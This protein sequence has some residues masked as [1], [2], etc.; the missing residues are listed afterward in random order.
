MNTSVAE[1][2]TPSEND[3][4]V[5]LTK[6]LINQYRKSL[7]DRECRQQT[8]AMYSCYLNKL[9]D[10]LQGDKELSD[11]NLKHW[12]ESLRNR[13]YSDRT[14]NMYISSVNGLLRFCGHKS[15]PISVTS[16]P[17]N[18]ELPGLT[19]EEYL[20]LLSYI[21]KYGSERDY[22]LTKTLGTMDINVMD[23]SFLTVEACQKGFV[24]L[25]DH[26]QAVITD[27]LKR[28]L[29]LYIG[30]KGLSTG[31][32]FITNQGNPIDRSNLT[33]LIERYGE[34]AGLDSRK[35][36]PRALHS[37]YQRTQEEITQQLMS[38]HMQEYEKLLDQEEKK[39]G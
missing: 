37:L 34:E 35:C 23:L 38:L 33:H 26:R 36:N 28:D 20:Q 31:S 2:T 18:V 10:F 39:V 24:E 14:I 19:R 16:A 3:S 7:E 22:L 5:K 11:E 6:E 4:V 32:V 29:I 27:N 15:I 25:P 9:Y 1:K 21:K 13:G 8:I 12:I 30:R 17:Q